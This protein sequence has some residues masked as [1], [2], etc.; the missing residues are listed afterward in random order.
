MSQLWNDVLVAVKRKRHGDAHIMTKRT[1]PAADSSDAGSA[2]QMVAA[3]NSIIADRLPEGAPVVPTVLDASSPAPAPFADKADYDRQ[4]GEVRRRERALG[5]DHACAVRAR[6]E[7]V[8]ADAILQ[9]LKKMD[10]KNVYDAAKPR[11]GYAG[12]R[13][14]RRPGDHFLSNVE[15]IEKT[16][17]F[18]VAQ[19]MPKGAH[20]HIHFNS[21]LQPEVLLDVARGM[22]R[23]FIW[24][25][26]PLTPDDDY[27]NYERCELQFSILP[28]EREDPGNLFHASYTPKQTMQ[29][30]AFLAAF[31]PDYP[32]APTAYA[33]LR[34][35]LLFNE[36]DAHDKLQT[37]YGAWQKFNGRTRMMKGLFNYESAY[38]TYTRALLEDFVRDN[39]QYAEIR[40]NFMTTNQ[41]RTDDGVGEIGNVGIMEII[42][43]EY[44]RFQRE[45]EGGYFAG[46][47]V[48]Y[49]TPRSFDPE[50]VEAAL[51]ECL[52]FKK[53]WPRWIAGSVA[54]TL[55]PSSPRT[56]S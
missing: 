45:K 56:S 38:R 17:V 46:L 6:K 10:V 33:W 16:H 34:R 13:H 15:L 1:C 55:P 7:E 21:C 31:P 51:N 50:A 9:R 8:R 22:D 11:T 24:S 35:K 30:R 39:I 43:E 2:R 54:S 52:E 26:M 27:L 4:R 3:Q 42:I 37:S 48:I 49:C 44:E 19:R 47:K 23:M 41:L 53:R 25:N 14:K 36:D 18:R 20:L 32:Y 28:P 5:F 29:F 40:P 12:Q